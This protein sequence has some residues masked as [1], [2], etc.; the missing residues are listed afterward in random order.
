MDRDVVA[1]QGG[2]GRFD[3]F[4]RTRRVGAVGDVEQ[5]KFHVF[6]MPASGAVADDSA[7]RRWP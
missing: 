7:P 6:I 1:P 4:E 5:F 2:Q 3:P